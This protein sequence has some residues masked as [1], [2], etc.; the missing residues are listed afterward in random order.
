[1]LRPLRFLRE[2]WRE[3]TDQ[4]SC[5]DCGRKCPDAPLPP[6]IRLTESRETGCHWCYA[7]LHDA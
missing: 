2:S 7:R 6:L 1:M 4:C 5:R 3:I